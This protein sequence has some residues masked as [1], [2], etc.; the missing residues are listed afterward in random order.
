MASK[1]DKSPQ[2]LKRFIL[3]TVLGPQCRLCLGLQA[4]GHVRRCHVAQKDGT[5]LLPV[6]GAEIM[7]RISAQ[8]ALRT[9][10]CARP[11]ILPPVESGVCLHTASREREGVVFYR[12]PFTRHMRLISRLKVLSAWAWGQ[13]MGG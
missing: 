9:I 1:W 2:S 8:C 4:F 12:W 5:S 13:S 11:A 10:P 3:T 7:L 6:G